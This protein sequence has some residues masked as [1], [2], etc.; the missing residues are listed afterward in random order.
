MSYEEDI[1]EMNL[2]YERERER[3]G[4]RQRGDDGKGKGRESVI[5]ETLPL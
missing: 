5:Y 1:W 3:E 4:R 2:I